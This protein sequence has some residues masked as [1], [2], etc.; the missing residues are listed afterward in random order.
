VLQAAVNIG[1]TDYTQSITRIEYDHIL[2]Q[3]FLADAQAK[4]V[5]LD[6]KKTGNKIGY[7]PGAGDNIPACL[8]QIGYEVAVLTDEL[9]AKEDLSVYSAIVT[10]IRAYNTNDR[11]PVYYDKLMAYV[12]QGGNL[13]VQYNT[14][15]R[16]APMET[17]IGPYPFTISRDRVTDDNA[18]VTFIN[19]QHP[20]LN[21]PNIITQKDFEGW[22]QERGIYF[23]TDLDA[24][25]ETIFSMND[26][27]EAPHKG[28]LII[29]PY[30]SFGHVFYGNIN[31]RICAIDAHFNLNIGIRRS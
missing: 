11:M 29:A 27:N 2:Y 25:Y 8:T 16:I 30:D 23:A 15:N 12:Q 1:G 19:P 20:V 17:K 14:N 4:I 28:S 31:I 24:H 26:P 18:N 13:I 7:I 21:T 10:G 6:L 5:F 3:F 22:I 9:L